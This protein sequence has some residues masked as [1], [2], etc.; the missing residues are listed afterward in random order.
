MTGMPPDPNIGA[1][2]RDPGGLKEEIAQALA[3]GRNV[4]VVRANLDTR[5]G[6]KYSVASTP[7]VAPHSPEEP[8]HADAQQGQRGPHLEEA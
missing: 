5:S 1:V 6:D 4:F 8:A 3:A 2:L 7:D